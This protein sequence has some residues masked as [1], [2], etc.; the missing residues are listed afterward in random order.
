MIEP[1]E[2]EWDD[3]VD[4]VCVGTEPAVLAYAVAAESVGMDVIVTRSRARVD[5]LT[6]AARLGLSDE[7]ADYVVAVTEDAPLP[8][9]PQALTVRCAGVPLWPDPGPGVSFS[10]AALRNWAGSCLGSPYGL[11]ST[12]VA[13]LG[14]ETLPVGTVS[15]EAVEVG[16][17]LQDRC[18]EFEVAPS[19][20]TCLGSL[21][22]A[23]GQVFG[24]VI[25]SPDGGSRVRAI[26]GVVFSTWT[27]ASTPLVAPG[28]LG[29]TGKAELVV[30]RRAFS[31][32]ARLELQVPVGEC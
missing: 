1:A 31:R 26:A 29:G 21:V 30:R 11:L 22:F 5:A 23:E 13:S 12:T 2:L 19:E 9:E 7:S 8:A 28:A 15:G 4:I 6:L 25:E 18:D 16:R 27:G 3:E 24:A 14:E 10:G 20:R 17:W 32:F